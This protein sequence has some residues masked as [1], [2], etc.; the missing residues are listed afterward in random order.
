ME[1]NPSDF[2]NISIL[3]TGSL[4][5]GFTEGLLSLRNSNYFDIYHSF[6]SAY[7]AG[8][9]LWGNDTILAARDSDH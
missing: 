8:H 7:R 4:I 9:G 1:F 2:P 5:L 3:P 6:L